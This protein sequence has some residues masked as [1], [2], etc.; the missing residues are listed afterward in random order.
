M[1]RVCR[2]GPECHWCAIYI[3][4][5]RTASSV[6]FG[7]DLHASGRIKRFLQISQACVRCLFFCANVQLVVRV[8][9]TYKRLAITPESSPIQLAPNLLQTTATSVQLN[10]TDSTS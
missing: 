2:C 8:T 7:Y 5:R 4:L 1:Q 10:L 3:Q 9:S 6:A